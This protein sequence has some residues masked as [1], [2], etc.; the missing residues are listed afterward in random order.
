M[1]QLATECPG[2]SVLLD[3]LHAVLPRAELSAV[4]AHLGSCSSCRLVASEARRSSAASGDAPPLAAGAHVHRFVILELIGAGAMGAVYAAYDPLLDRRCALKFLRPS[5]AADGRHDERQA[6]LLQ[7]ARSLAR[8]NHPHVVVVHEVATFSVDGVAAIYVAE[9]FIRGA[10]LADWLRAAPRSVAEVL[11]VFRQAGDGLAAAHRAGIVHRDFKP[12]NVLVGDDGRTRVVDFGLARLVDDGRGSEAETLPLSSDALAPPLLTVTGAVI[13]TPFYM[14][15]EQHA[16]RA[17]DARSD[18]FSFCVAL[19]EALFGCRPFASTN[20]GELRRAVTHGQIVPPPSDRRVPSWLRAVVLRGLSAAA[21]DRFA[22][23]E[24]LLA[25]LRVERRPRGIAA[26]IT[27]LVVASI[28]LALVVGGRLQSRREL[29]QGGAAQLAHV[30]DAPR[31]AQVQAALVATGV[32]YATSIGSS[33]AH[34][35]DGYG[36]AWLRMHT[37]ACQATR[38]RGEQS[39][40]ALDLRMSCLSDRLVELD[41]AAQELA[42]ADAKSAARALEIV[43]GLPAVTACANVEALKLPVPLPKDSGARAKVAEV[44]AHIVRAKTLAE[45]GRYQAALTAAEAAQKE[46]RAIAYGPL[47]A[48]ALGQLGWQ[49]MESRGA[50]EPT[51]E[52]AYFTAEAA[53]DDRQAVQAA[54]LLATYV[55]DDLARPKDGERWARA[56]RALMNRHVKDAGEEAKLD[57]VLGDLDQTQNRGEDALRHYR[58]AV[59]NW[60]LAHGADNA[61]SAVEWTKM[62]TTLIQLGK[63]DEAVVELRRSLALEERLYGAEHPVVAT[64]RLELGA[65]LQSQGK[66]DEALVEERRALAIDTREADPNLPTCHYDIGNALRDQGAHDQALAEYRQALSLWQAALGPAHPKVAVAHQA[67]GGFFFFQL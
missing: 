12:A 62:G 56:A 50:A 35:L 34:T 54:L 64:T 17:V 4:E 2:P 32:P 40:E 45:A 20:L 42:S 39:E 30:W 25:A 6:R 7:E 67:L 1:E 19:Y 15:P 31:K 14:S 43:G 3:Y 11:Q 29:C 66:Y 60:D 23:M 5:S 44:Q 27:L 16:S 57:E 21:A 18:Q 46:A 41:A 63:Y 47:Q 48:K 53:K 37:D 33:V 59:A 8:L 51:L 24:A 28:G 49:Q 36:A 58:N 55:G 9:E 38:L 26:G 22:S 65:A 61:A 10:N 52:D 13:G